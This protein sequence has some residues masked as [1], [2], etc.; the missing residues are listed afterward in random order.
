MKF[1]LGRLGEWTPERRFAVERE[2]IQAYA[3][4]TNETSAAFLDGDVEH[5]LDPRRRHVR[6]LPAGTR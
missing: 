6:V 4:A 5:R 2:R 1:E 3:A